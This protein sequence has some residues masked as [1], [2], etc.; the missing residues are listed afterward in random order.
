MTR[1]H[2]GNKPAEGRVLAI[3]EHFGC[4]QQLHDLGIP[5]GGNQLHLSC[6]YEA[7][8][9]DLGPFHHCIWP[10]RRP[11]WY[12]CAPS[13]GTFSVSMEELISG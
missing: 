7:Q 10:I 3:G 11:H 5:E 9:Y 8:H 2:V 13:I 1:L 12:V 4:S 6:L